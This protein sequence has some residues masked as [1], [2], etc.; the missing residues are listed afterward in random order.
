MENWVIFKNSPRENNDPFG[1]SFKVKYRELTGFLHQI[2]LKSISFVIASAIMLSAC[3]GGGGPSE[4][5]DSTPFSSVVGPS[6]PTVS[7]PFSS[8]VGP[9][10]PT[11]STPF[12]SVI[13]QSSSA[14]AQGKI[15]E[16]AKAEPVFGS[17]TQSSNID[18]QTGITTDIVSTS[19]GYN[20]NGQIIY[21]VV[22]GN[23]WDVDSSANETTTLAEGRGPSGDWNYIE[24]QKNLPDGRLWVD[25]YT[26]FGAAGTDTDY[27]AGGI[28]VYVPDDAMNVNQF[29][30]GAFVDGADPYTGGIVALTGEYTY[31]GDATGVYSVLAEKRNYFFDA[32]VTLTADFEISHS[33]GT[34]W[35]YVDNFSVDD[36]LVE[37]NPTLYLGSADIGGANP[38]FF[39]G[40][41]DTTYDGISYTGKW[42]GQFFGNDGVSNPPGSVG[43]TFG[44]A[45]GAAGSGDEKSILGVFGAFLDK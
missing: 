11:V 7:T 35:G 39:T 22:N 44:A 31:S 24:M 17:V 15:A 41:T 16:A 12:S 18:T 28:W 10:E 37:S 13:E 34:I 19:V 45:T 3:G 23:N 38:D 36:E 42:G 25:V 32:D 6:E 8:V 9:S 30:F 40:D 5:T 20:G 2:P 14:A 26:N 27:L 29:E 33:F 1:Y 43:G 21:T 4:I